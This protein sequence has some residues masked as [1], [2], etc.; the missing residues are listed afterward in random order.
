MRTTL[1]H[2]LHDLGNHVP[3]AADD[4]G[5]ADHQAQAC[6]LVH[7]VQGGVGHRH[8]GHLDRL[9]PRYG[10]DRAGA[11]DLE[12]HVEQFG[13]FFHRWKLVGNGPARLAGPETQ[14]ALRRQAV[15]LEHH[16]VDFIR[17]L[18]PPCA[19]VVVVLQALLDVLG[20]LE[21]ATDR[22]APLLELF[23]IA[24]VGGGDVLGDLAD[25]V[26]AEFQGAAGGDFRIQLAQAAGC[27]V[28]RVGE[29]LAA[30]FHLAGVE[31]FEPGLGHEH[32]AAHFQHRRP[33]AAVQLER[34][35]ADGAHVDADVFAGGAI[36]AGRAADQGAVLV[37]QRHRQAVE[38]GF[39]AVVNRSAAAE[40]VTGGQVE[41][42]GDTAVE[43]AQVDFF[44]GVAE[45][46][47]GDFVANLGE[48]GQGRIA[49]AL[50][51]RVGGD[52]V[53]VVGFKGLEFA[54]QTVVFGIGDAGFVE[55][56][57]AVVVLVEFGTQFE[58]TVGVVH[59]RFSLE[60]KEQPWLL[61]G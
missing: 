9:E 23:E 40:Q 42:F 4:H 55:H 49:D 3:R 17:Q 36:A 60:A 13:E 51:G 50:G 38:L 39:A 25:A 37:K 2:H 27:G 7:V 46:E 48:R 58:D 61:L 24:G 52:Q 43:L 44:E 15:D 54:E 12:F 47:H 56:V 1:G 6:H 32:L 11:A 22:H 5:V 20:D 29:G 14:L 16:T 10:C 19:D 57:V 26:A 30:D 45:A 34:D 35:V 21:F 28:A 53:R 31:P 8:A 41:A 33:T 59:D 18:G